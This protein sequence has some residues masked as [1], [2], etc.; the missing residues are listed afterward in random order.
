[1]PFKEPVNLPGE[2]SE[3]AV[4]RLAES[5]KLA[6]Q[7]DMPMPLGESSAVVAEAAGAAARVDKAQAT[8]LAHQIRQGEVGDAPVDWTVS[9]AKRGELLAKL[10]RVQAEA[11]KMLPPSAPAN[12]SWLAKARAW[13]GGGEPESRETTQ[14]VE[15]PTTV[16]AEIRALDK[17]DF[18]MLDEEL[19]SKA[20]PQVAS[21]AFLH[22]VASRL[23]SQLVGRPAQIK[24]PR[25][26]WQQIVDMTNMLDS[27]TRTKVQPAIGD[28]ARNHLA[29][30]RRK[31]GSL[32]GRGNWGGITFEGGEMMR[33]GRPVSEE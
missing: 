2:T 31:V 22:F 30:A 10:R 19:G 5:L 14:P 9:L 28:A 16:R 29:D 13:V 21:Q 27:C 8:A 11:E 23:D 33:D 26:L 17:A 32:V 24:D 18:Q 6:S 12:R 15:S 3:Q 1:M 25:V 4:A 7:E 20:D